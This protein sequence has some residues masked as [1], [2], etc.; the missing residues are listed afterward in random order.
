MLGI[1]VGTFDRIRTISIVFVIFSALVAFGFIRTVDCFVTELLTAKASI[2]SNKWLSSNGWISYAVDRNVR[3]LEHRL[4]IVIRSKI[5]ANPVDRLAVSKDSCHLNS[6]WISLSDQRS[7][8][9]DMSFTR[10][11][12]EHNRIGRWSSAGESDLEWQATD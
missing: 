11:S 10:N 2:D 4:K 3:A 12:I 7:H 8:G 5:N 1:A 9:I 6:R